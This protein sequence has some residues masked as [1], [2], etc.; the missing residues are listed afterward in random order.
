[1]CSGKQAEVKLVGGRNSP[2][3]MLHSI[4]VV[5]YGLLMLTILAILDPFIFMVVHQG[6]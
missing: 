1:M 5:C 2:T 6:P 4:A 3:S